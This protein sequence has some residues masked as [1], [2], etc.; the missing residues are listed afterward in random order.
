[1]CRVHK[2]IYWNYHGL[3]NTTPHSY[4]RTG[5]DIFRWRELSSDPRE[6][7]S[8]PPIKDDNPTMHFEYT[9]KVHNIQ[10]AIPL[11]PKYEKKPVPHFRVEFLSDRGPP[12]PI[13][14][15]V[16]INGLRDVCGNATCEDPPER[17]PMRSAIRPTPTGC[18]QGGGCVDTSHIS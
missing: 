4:E 15:E 16:E 17:P 5:D 2:N 9:P 11:R 13:S 12:P 6:Y 7:P 8:P 1:M 3:I 14:K 10:M 18:G